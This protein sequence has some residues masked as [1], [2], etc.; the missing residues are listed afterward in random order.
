MLNGYKG[1]PSGRAPQTRGARGP[2]RDKGGHSQD[3]KSPRGNCGVV[4]QEETERTEISQK[5][6]KE[7]K[8]ILTTD[9]HGLFT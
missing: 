7:T 6:T 3:A 5:E 9:G 4:L 1:G 8:G 2:R